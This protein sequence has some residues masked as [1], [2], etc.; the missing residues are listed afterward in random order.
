[1]TTLAARKAPHCGATTCGTLPEGIPTG[2]FSPYTQAVLATLAGGYRLSKRQIQ[3]LASDLFGLTIS[4][5]MIAKLDWSGSRPTCWSNPWPSWP[6]GSK[7][8]PTRC[9]KER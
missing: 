4:I 3:Q 6:S 7:W 8:D 9:C 1:M 2:H 5:G